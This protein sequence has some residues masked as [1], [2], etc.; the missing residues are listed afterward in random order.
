VPIAGDA[1]V[2]KT[3]VLSEAELGYTG[4]GWLRCET[5][6]SLGV[7]NPALTPLTHAAAGLHIPDDVGMKPAHYAIHVEPA[8]R[9]TPA[10]SCSAWARTPRPDSPPTTWNSQHPAG[11]QGGHRHARVHGHRE[12]HGVP[13]QRSRLLQGHARG[14]R[15]RAPGGP[16]RGR[17]RP[18]GAPN[19][20]ALYP[21]RFLVLGHHRWA[22]TI[23]A[24][25]AY[26]DRVHGWRSLHLYPG[27]DPAVLIHRIPRAVHTHVV[28]LRH[29][30]PCA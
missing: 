9:T 26:M 29:P 1:G 5:D 15:L 13:R 4:R 11:G 22:H 27:D 17:E 19:D 7:W 14:R 20:D 18:V 23:E 28:F 21:D 2:C 3:W 25:A 12:G 10:A 16:P 6:K 8:G 24:A 30:H